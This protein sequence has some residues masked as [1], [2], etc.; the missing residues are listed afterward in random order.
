MEGT[1]CGDRHEHTKCRILVC[2]IGRCSGNPDCA[3]AFSV[4][5]GYALVLVFAIW[6]FLRMR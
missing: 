6:L 4:S 2:V 3:A 5:F 1:P